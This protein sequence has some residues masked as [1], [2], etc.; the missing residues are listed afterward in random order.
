MRR[1]CLCLLVFCTLVLIPVSVSAKKQT[2]HIVLDAGHGGE[3]A[4]A[5]ADD[6][7]STVF[8]KDLNLKVAKAVGRNLEKY[9]G[10]SVSYTREE[11]YSLDLSKR[12]QIAKENDADILISIHHNAVGEIV[13][14]DQGCTVLTGRGVYKK[15]TCEEQQKLACNILYELSELGLE[16]QGILLRQS[17]T[18]SVY[19][20]GEL[21]DYYAIIR[22]GLEQGVSSILIEH[23]F[24][25]SETDYSEFLSSDDK[26]EQIAEADAK[27][28]A[29]YYRLKRKS[30]G[31]PEEKLANVEETLTLVKSGD[32]ADNEISGK[33]FYKQKESVSTQKGSTE[34]NLDEKTDTDS[35]KTI[36]EKLFEM[37][38]LWI[39]D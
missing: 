28:I 13:D 6:H 3:D 37:I 18:G 1:L 27:G 26:L 11:D 9:E 31:K 7:G 34:Q 8:E 32:S 12:T 4:G 19:P 15:K 39:R 24:L 33:T 36:F 20:N 17:E 29:R 35:D 38:R 2:I 10:V 21:A 5:E 22:N 16:D 25:D 30:D 23:A 14:Y